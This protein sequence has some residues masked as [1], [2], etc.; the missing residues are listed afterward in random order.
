[1]TALE[2]LVFVAESEIQY[3]PSLPNVKLINLKA[4]K[5]CSPHLILT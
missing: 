4:L 5:K 2:L 3:S 1:M